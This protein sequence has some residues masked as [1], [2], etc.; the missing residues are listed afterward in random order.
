[1]LVHKLT[2]VRIGASL[3][4]EGLYIVHAVDDSDDEEE[5]EEVEDAVEH[6][7]FG[8]V[9]EVHFPAE[10]GTG[11]E[12]KLCRLRCVQGR[13]VGPICGSNKEGDEA[14]TAEW[15]LNH[16]H[17]HWI[18]SNA[19]LYI[20]SMLAIRIIWFHCIS[21]LKSVDPWHKQYF[22]MLYFQ[23]KEYGDSHQ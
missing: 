21:G 17:R 3:D 7:L 8:E 12:R 14:I 18:I 6:D 11:G 19:S 9:T 23:A 1:M 5:E 13:W 20:E 4:E 15:T 22:S 16:F 2:G 10:L